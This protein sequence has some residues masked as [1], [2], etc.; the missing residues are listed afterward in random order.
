MK[1]ENNV[2]GLAPHI[3]TNDPP[4]DYDAPNPGTCRV[5]FTMDIPAASEAFIE[6][7]LTPVR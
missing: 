5:G 2:E 7:S 6:V 3:W 1:L 4:H